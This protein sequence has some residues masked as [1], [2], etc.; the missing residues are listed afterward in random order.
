MLAEHKGEIPF[1]IY[2]MPFLAGIIAGLYF[3]VSV[4]ILY[5]SIA[6]LFCFFL[7]LNL[8]FGKANIYNHSWIGGLLIHLLLFMIGYTALELND[9]RTD[10]AYF[11]KQRAD[12]LLVRVSNEP[13]VKQKY[14]R[15]IADV[16]Q[17]GDLYNQR[18]AS[19]KLLL[20]IM[21][22]ERHQLQYGDELLIPAN[23]R[24]VDPP[25]NPAGFNYKAYLAHQNIYAQSFL[26]PGQYRVMGYQPA[27]QIINSALKTRQ[28]FVSLFKANIK[29][30][31]AAAIASTLILGYK[32]DL[33]P[34]VTQT[35]SRTG[36][37]HVL[38]VSGAHVAVVYAFIAF[39]LGLLKHSRKTQWLKAIIAILLIWAYA[40]LTGFSPA[41]C[42]AA[43]MVSMVI[44][45]NT[46]FQ[47][48][49]MANLLAF[50]AFLLLLYNPLMLVDVGFQLSYLAVA[51]LLMF[52]PVI[53]NWITFKS[54]YAA[55]LWYYISA[56]LAAQLITFPLSAYYF[57]QFPVYF[58]ISNLLI[59][60]PSAVILYS[61]LS[62][63]LLSM[64]P[65]LKSVAALGFWL[66][67]KTLTYMTMALSWIEHLP[68]ASVNKLWYT[69]PDCLLLS[70]MVLLLF[71]FFFN[72]QVRYLT[73]SLV[74]LLLFSASHSYGAI[75]LAGDNSITFF[76][77]NKH[78]AMLLKNGSQGTAITDLSA[79]DP[80]FKYTIQPA[81]DSLGIT[82]LTIIN[83]NEDLSKN[84][85]KKR[86]DLLQ[87]KQ[88]R[89]FM[90]R[91]EYLP[92]SGKIDVDY[93]YVTGNPHFQLSD[94][95]QMIAYKMLVIDAT[96]SAKNIE[97]M[98]AEAESL[99]IKYYVLKRNKSLTVSSN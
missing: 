27:N 97:C 87:F 31:T 43:L 68:Y 54:K 21:P 57:H 19:G 11:E 63:L 69:L 47:Y 95:S 51:G 81:A 2:L 58:L 29:D 83:Q 41:V 82:Y 67:E 42:R 92:G 25:A 85:L 96:N 46:S 45:G 73:A 64:V 13:V 44:I 91:P 66:L 36:T 60:L 39:L 93:L 37:I 16:L 15:C 34:E 72:R 33:S 32:A 40:L 22:D 12:L 86:N 78:Q 80:V 76:S 99:K 5:I 52:Q 50:S 56:S 49:N 48:V 6:V 9:N 38:S 94:I 30:T 98:V 89:V 62:A 53:N 70:G 24:A 23:Y 71:L 77:I 75:K 1:L 4:E 8:T 55:T 10:K 18:K 14:V 3:P 17:C 59:I 35:Y 7:A 65:F 28:Y 84:Y 74:C 26:Y 88:M 79:A 20:T 61:G 90:L